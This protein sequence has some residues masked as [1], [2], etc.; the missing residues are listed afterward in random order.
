MMSLKEPNSK[1]RR[2]RKKL[3][4]FDYENVCKLEKNNSDADTLLRI[5]IEVEIAMQTK[6]YNTVHIQNFL[7][8]Q[9]Q[10]MKQTHLMIDNAF[11]CYL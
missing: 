11:V 9:S 5:Q 7:M 1:L 3:E 8:I 4:E 6:V 10:L 2:R